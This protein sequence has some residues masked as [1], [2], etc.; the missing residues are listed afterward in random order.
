MVKTYLNY[1]QRDLNLDAENKAHI[2]LADVAIPNSAMRI[3]I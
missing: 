2:T 3:I 1:E